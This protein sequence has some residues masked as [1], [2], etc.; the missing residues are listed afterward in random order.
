MAAICADT[1]FNGGVHGAPAWNSDLGQQNRFRDYFVSRSRL[2]LDGRYR[3]RPSAAWCAPSAGRLPVQQCRLSSNPTALNTFPELQRR[4]RW[5]VP[6]GGYV[7][8][9]YLFIQFAG[10][11][12]R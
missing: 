6:G 8:V 10:F 1:T 12:F 9:E 11:T 2:A 3:P 4:T 7:A 5:M